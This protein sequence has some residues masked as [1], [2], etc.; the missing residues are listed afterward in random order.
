MTRLRIF[1]DGGARPNPGR[2]EIAAVARGVDYVQRDVGTGSGE[3]AEWLALLHAARIAKGLGATDVEFVGDAAAIVDRA[4][5]RAK[6][7]TAVQRER[8]AAFEAIADGF[9]KVRVRRVA[10]AKNL[11]GIA[12][13]RG[14]R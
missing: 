3:A 5:G 14:Y 13:A 12:L 2:M 7:R 4:S 6:C 10:R 8:L 9:A 1:F 11:A